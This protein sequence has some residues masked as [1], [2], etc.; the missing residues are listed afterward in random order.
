MAFELPEDYLR[1]PYCDFGSYDFDN[2]EAHCRNQHTSQRENSNPQP[3]ENKQSPSQP[4]LNDF[5][6]AQL[7]AFEEAGLPSELALHE[8]FHGPSLNARQEEERTGNASL[9]FPH[10]QPKD[11][12]YDAQSWVGCVCGERVQLLEFDAHADMHAQENVSGVDIDL[13]SEG[14]MSHPL[15]TEQS[16]RS[17]ADSFTTSISNSLRNV[18]QMLPRTPPSN[19]RKRLP[20]LKEILLG[21]PASPKGKSSYKAVSSKQGKTRRLGVSHTSYLESIAQSS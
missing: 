14:H 8:G 4:A 3:H 18:D 7:L 17:I 6:L 9:S 10:A 11:E 15:T 16:P 2:L 1:C 20:S 19:S 21:T 12:D 5:E 13:P